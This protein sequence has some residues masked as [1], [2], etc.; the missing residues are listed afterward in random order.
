MWGGGI[1]E[2]C[3]SVAVLQFG[4]VRFITVHIG[5]VA[6]GGPNR[7]DIHLKGTSAEL[8]GKLFMNYLHCT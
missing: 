5:G 1:D 7:R 4:S 2:I 8:M 6:F 3:K